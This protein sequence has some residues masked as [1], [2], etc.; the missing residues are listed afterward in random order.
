MK[1]F[2]SVLKGSLVCA[3]LVAS[4]AAQI[5]QNLPYQAVD[6]INANGTAVFSGAS[7]VNDPGR[8]QLPAYAIT[9]LLPPDADPKKVSVS[10]AGATE[11]DVPG[12]FDIKPGTPIVEGI[13]VKWPT[14]R[15]IVD[16]ED[17]AVYKTNAYYPKQALGAVSFSAFREYK[18][19]EVIVNPFRYN[20]VT[21]SLR[22]L[23]GGMIVVSG[24][25]AAS[26]SASASVIQAP[27]TSTA[28][29]RNRKKIYDLVANKGQLS[30]YPDAAASSSPSAPQ[31]TPQSASPSSSPSSSAA[32]AQSAAA[33]AAALG[34]YAIIC[35]GDVYWASTQLQ[36]FISLKKAQGY[37]V[38]PLIFDQYTGDAAATQIRSWLEANYLTQNIQFA[39]IIGSPA[40][41]STV[42]MKLLVSPGDTEHIPTDYYFAEL[43][44]PNGLTF[45]K[46]ADIAVG[47]I[48]YYGFIA[49]LDHILAKTIAYENS[50]ASN[51]AWRRNVLL[52]TVPSDDLTPG[53][54]FGE[55]VK[56]NI[57]GPNQFRYHR[58]YKD[59]NW[60]GL[61]YPGVSGLSSPPVETYP[62]SYE[63][64]TSVWKNNPFGLVMWWTHGNTEFAADILLRDSVPKLNDNF[65]T[66]AFQGSCENAWP[67]DSLN[68][69]YSL[70][71]NGAIATIAATRN[72]NYSGGETDYTNSS[73]NPGYMYQFA[74][75]FLDPESPTSVGW[76]LNYGRKF[77]TSPNF[78]NIYDYV[79]YGDPSAALN[80]EPK[81][82]LPGRIEAEGYRPG[83]EG[84]GY[85]DLTPGNAGGQFRPNDGVDI[86]PCVD[87]S[88]SYYVGST[89]AGEWLAYD[90]SVPQAG[91]YNIMARI[92]PVQ[93]ALKQWN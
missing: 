64:V 86:Y 71:K 9:F 80:S 2:D 69:A 1:L 73:S 85:H 45:D 20:A 91:V 78:R 16:G 27:S 52:A 29:G 4:A 7:P 60:S 10:I 82:V 5:T 75:Y 33:A 42:P 46:V 34:T 48:P 81:I 74:K 6:V 66:F 76:A 43:S 37:N 58:I 57:A 90:I 17:I 70:L 3:A 59:Y 47:R 65:P 15:T 19:V 72:S 14:D 55:A 56:N 77:I 24:V 39:L 38:V 87:N 88:F 51:N 8:P 44:D 36:N 11:I 89:Q 23:T 67:D 63:S 21:K 22:K 31:A 25:S 13:T 54:P 12:S 26:S 92:A 30:S 83:G 53:Y 28:A 68:L 61:E 32:S 41:T 35:Q 84:V 40:Q 49:D 93:S 50:P 18:L 62:C 79:I